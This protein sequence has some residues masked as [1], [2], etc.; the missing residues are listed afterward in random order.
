[1][2]FTGV[3]AAEGDDAFDRGVEVVDG[4]I[5]MDA[6]LPGLGFGDRLQIDAWLVFMPWG[7]LDPSGQARQRLTIK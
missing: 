5:Q 1:M 2:A 6:D 3:A 4:D 7:E